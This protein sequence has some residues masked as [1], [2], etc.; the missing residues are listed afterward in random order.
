MKGLR[1]IVIGTVVGA[2]STLPPMVGLYRDLAGHY[3]IDPERLQL[4]AALAIAVGLAVAVAGFER[5]IRLGVMAGG[6]AL[7]AGVLVPAALMSVLEAPPRGLHWRL[8]RQRLLANEAVLA[9]AAGCLVSVGAL[10]GTLRPRSLRRPRLRRV[11]L[12]VGVL[13]TAAAVA[14][15]ATDLAMLGPTYKVHQLVMP[16]ALHQ[17]AAVDAGAAAAE[18]LARRC[19]AGPSTITEIKVTSAALGSNRPALVELPAGYPECAPPGGYPV[20]YLLHGDP[21]KMRDWP[22]I[23]AQEIF[24]AGHASGLGAYIVVYPDGAGRWT[25]WSD[26]ADGSW[27]MGTFIATD[28]V[29]YIDHHYTTRTD[30]AGRF[31]GGFSSGGFGAASVAL[32]HPAT[33]GGYLALSGYFHTGLSVSNATRP[34][35]AAISPD[36]LAGNTEARWMHAVV[37]TGLQDGAYTEEAG[38]FRSQL[39][40]ASADLV[41]LEEPGGHGSH[42]WRDLLWAALPTIH[43]WTAPPA[44][45]GRT[46]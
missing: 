16:A 7:V 45:M 33:Y 6:A 1:S 9:V 39:T 2:A 31:I 36:Q 20:V 19:P 12:V 46:R 22:G 8:D 17:V 44:R 15:P 28:L 11:A 41:Y 42:L 21:G 29:G 32:T 37:G 38:R 23:G 4:I 10:L 35:P 26:S 24:D 14:H 13:A 5:S 25:D 40:A 3:E 18:V 27:R 34:L 43:Q 30:A